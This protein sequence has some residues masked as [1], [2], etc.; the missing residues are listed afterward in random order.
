[1]SV[2]ATKAESVTGNGVKENAITTRNVC[3]WYAKFLGQ[4]F[5]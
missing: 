4:L 2:T 5:C 1:M 3:L